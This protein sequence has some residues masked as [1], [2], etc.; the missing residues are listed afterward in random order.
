L[1]DIHN[2][3]FTILEMNFHQKLIL[4]LAKLFLLKK[5]FQDF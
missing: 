4:G 1:V 5:I 3:G 2:Y